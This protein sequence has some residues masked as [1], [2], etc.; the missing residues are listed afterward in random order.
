MDSQIVKG[1]LNI[2]TF[3]VVSGGLLLFFQERGTAE[4]IITI[5]VVIIGLVFAFG[6]ILAARISRR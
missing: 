2:A 4:F 6:I 5:T 1:G 3:L